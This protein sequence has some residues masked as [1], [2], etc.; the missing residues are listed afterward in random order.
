M[1]S[2][3][4]PNRKAIEL[5]AAKDLAITE[6]AS[7]PEVD[8]LVTDFNEIPEDSSPL[9]NYSNQ[10]KEVINVPP[11]VGLSGNEQ[12]RYGAESGKSSG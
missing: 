12:T 11:P 9:K 6:V 1:T 8:D 3:T 5:P 10:I 2:A 7:K 4:T